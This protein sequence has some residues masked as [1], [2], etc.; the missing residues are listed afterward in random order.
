MDYMTLFPAFMRDKPRFAALAQAILMQVSD[1]TDV[2]QAIP[3]AYSP[4]YAVGIQLDAVGE[5]SGLPRPAGMSDADY[6]QVLLA[7]FAICNWDGTNETA[8][9]VLSSAFPG[10]TISDNVNGTVTVRTASQLQADYRLFPLPA[11]VQ[12]AIS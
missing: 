9:A 4:E 8:Q 2:I 5:A 10:S 11:G 1:L 12:A 3:A 6:R 7:S